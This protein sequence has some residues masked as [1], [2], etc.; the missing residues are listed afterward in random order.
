MFS[1]P[2]VMTDLVED[3][4]GGIV[5]AIHTAAEVQH[6]RYT[7]QDATVRAHSGKVRAV[8][9]VSAPARLDRQWVL[10]FLRER[11]I[12][13]TGREPVGL[14]ADRDVC[15]DCLDALC[16]CPLW[17]DR[18]PRLSDARSVA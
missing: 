5:F 1:S 17:C 16:W 6:W 13:V 9:A 11:G 14:V 3:A 12:D 7:I 2:D 4:E 18:W 10:E 8:L 15:G